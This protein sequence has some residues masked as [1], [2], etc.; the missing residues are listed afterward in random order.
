MITPTALSEAHMECRSLDATVPVLT[1]LLAFERI[2][3]GS[4][5]AT[6]KHPST[7][8]LLTV[9]EAGSDSAEKP[10]HHHFG[11]RVETKREVDAA[12]EYLNAH[13]DEYGL[14]ELKPQAYSHGSYS[15]HFREPGANDWEIECYEDVLRKESGALRL[16]GVRSRHWEAPVDES[17]FRGRGYVPQAFTH[18]TLACSDSKAYG[19][20]LREVLGLETHDAYAHVVYLKHPATKHYVVC[21]E[22]PERNERSS[23]FRFTLTVDSPVAVEEAHES[24]A[25]AERALGLVALGEIEGDDRRWFLLRD[26]DANWWEISS[27]R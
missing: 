27:P 24:L 1:D 4:G 18:G 3:H 16:G 19:E 25:A 11:V 9:H 26:A 22:R 20:F 5:W 6:V 2:A 21:L 8:W 14:F 17:Q 13:A 12:W 7:P 23:D 10:A 15:I